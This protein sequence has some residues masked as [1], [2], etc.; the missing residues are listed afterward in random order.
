M[1]IQNIQ[2][3]LG[4]LSEVVVN[5]DLGWSCEVYQEAWKVT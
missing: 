5:S 4:R 2:Q 3:V 1:G